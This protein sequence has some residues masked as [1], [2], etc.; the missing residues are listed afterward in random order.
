MKKKMGV[1]MTAMPARTLWA[2][3]QAKKKQWLSS[4]QQPTPRHFRRAGEPPPLKQALRL[5]HRKV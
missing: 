3:L 1:P 4:S 2:A 5:R